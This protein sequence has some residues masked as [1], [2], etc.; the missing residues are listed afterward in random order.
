MKATV[1]NSQDEPDFPQ[2]NP[3]QQKSCSKYNIIS[4]HRLGSQAAMI[5]KRLLK[6]LLDSRISYLMPKIRFGFIS[7]KTFSA[8]LLFAASVLLYTGPLQES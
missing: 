2:P 4:Q 1:Y 6:V 5:K 3:H 8:A 7:L